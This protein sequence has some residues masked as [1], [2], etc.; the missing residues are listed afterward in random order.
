MEL[1][2]IKSINGYVKI[3]G[4]KSISHR[5][6]IIASLVNKPV[7]IKNF[8]F[9]E[10]CI[11]TIETLKKLGVRIE[12]N[13]NEVVVYGAGI[14]G[15]KEPDE[16]LE[17]VNSGTTIRLISGIIAG[18]NILS[19]LSG[20]HS[21]NNRPMDRII[22]PL[23]EMGAE[24]YGRCNNKKAPII[25]FGSN[26]L[27]GKKF[28]LNISSA[29]VK[30]CISLAAL[31]AEGTT[32]IIQ[33]QVS[34]DHT[35]R[36]LEY[37]ESD[38]DYNGRYT[39]VNPKKKLKA[40][41]LVIPGDISSALFL[42]V[43]A[44]ILKDSHIIIKDIG[45][46]PTRSY[47]IDILKNMGGFINIK[48][49]RIICN[50][51]VGDIEVSSSNLFPANIDTDK[52]PN[53]IDEIPALCVAASKA[54]GTTV[55]KGAGELRYKESDRIKAIAS[56]FKKAGV[57]I[58]ELK[59]GLIIRGNKNLKI[60]GCS[61][62]SLGDHRIAMSLSILSMLSG[63]KVYISDTDCINTSFPGFDNIFKSIS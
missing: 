48:N 30:S 53:I 9:S 34:R 15:L 19:V 26:T 29:Q 39:R 1:S 57:D 46:N 55:I 5:S 33:P 16:I 20:D 60:K 11:C 12:I 36:M 4:D 47:I 37:F 2:G 27:K 31:H 8:L 24:V 32:E 52:I 35:E 6:V 44:I 58:K 45:I 49:K 54:D 23:N 50:E 7:R 38:I 3:P 17:V 51:P 28:E 61:L 13:D 25:I 42:I 59:D 18:N 41:D 40:K 56:Q 10:D 62:D 21:V 22:K 63:E 14:S 43:A